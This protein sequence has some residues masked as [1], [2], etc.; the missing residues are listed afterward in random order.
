M[1]RI[2][3]LPENVNEPAGL[4]S[5]IRL[6]RGGALLESDRVL[7]HSPAFTR[8]WNEIAVAVREQLRLSPRLLEL[9][10][11]GVGIL[12]G[13]LYEFDKH[14]PEFRRYGGTEEQAAALRNFDL[15]SADAELFD[16]TDR[17]VMQLTIEMTRNV[18]VTDATFKSVLKILIEP[19]LMVDL[20]GTV[21]MYNMVS[22]MLV[23]F[24][25]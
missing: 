17:A 16:E 9:A 1:S 8:G 20:V 25:I 15:A 21:A 10:I 23:A 14:I 7:L 4:V 12:N 5:A 2:P 24:E 22:R 18:R 11:C 19:E 13:A 6:R 3:M